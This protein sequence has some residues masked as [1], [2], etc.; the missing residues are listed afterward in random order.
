MQGLDMLT[1]HRA[2]HRRFARTPEE[3][4]RSYKRTAFSGALALLLL[5][6]LLGGTGC[7]DDDPQRVLADATDDS[8]VEYNEAFRIRY[9]AAGRSNC[10]DGR[11][12][13]ESDDLASFSD[14]VAFGRVTDIQPAI[15]PLEFSVD[16][17]GGETC[18]GTISPG[19]DITIE[20][21]ATFMRSSNSDGGG[22]DEPSVDDSFTLRITNRELDKVW[23]STVV[24]ENGIINWLGTRQIFVGD[25][26]A[27]SAVYIEEFDLFS[28]AGHP[29]A[30]IDQDRVAGTSGGT[31]R[32]GCSDYTYADELYQGSVEDFRERLSELV[33]GKAPALDGALYSARK[34][35]AVDTFI[36]GTALC[37]VAPR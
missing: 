29:F 10:P 33:S 21:D 8:S 24:I 13:Y 22:T 4:A 26:I 35:D 1:K 12:V 2:L 23:D 15:V 18:N 14:I 30:F 7:N 9:E 25:T 36:P 16:G 31:Y 32:F 6:T 5:S 17:A 11:M 37:F 34:S 20:P 3:N 19:I 28:L 27:V